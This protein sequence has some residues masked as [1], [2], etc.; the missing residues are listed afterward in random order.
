MFKFH[1][2]LSSTCKLNCAFSNYLLFLLLT[3]YL[4]KFFIPKHSLPCVLYNNPFNTHFL[5]LLLMFAVFYRLSLFQPFCCDQTPITQ[6]CVTFATN[7]FRDFKSRSMR[8]S[9]MT[10]SP[11]IW[12]KMGQGS[13]R[14][15]HIGS[16]SLRRKHTSRCFPT[17][18]YHRVGGN[19]TKNVGEITNIRTSIDQ[20]MK[21]L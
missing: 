13:G 21:F 7:L 18:H 8:V 20:L 12:I 10:Q 17:E 15:K 3:P 11:S 19:G 1:L 5:E 9:V 6:Y 2:M 14:M 16:Y 4:L